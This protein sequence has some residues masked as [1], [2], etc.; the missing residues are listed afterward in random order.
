MCRRRFD[1][2][3]DSV[4]LVSELQCHYLSRTDEI[5][6]T[7]AVLIPALGANVI[8][9]S[10]LP[11]GWRWPIPV[12]ESVD[13]ASVLRSPTS[14]G[15][16]LLAPTP[17][18]V[19]Q[20]QSGRFCYHGQ[21]YRISPS[22]HGFLRDLPWRV[23][24]RA[25]DSITCDIE[26]TPSVNAGVIDAFPFRFHAEHHVQLGAGSLRS[27][28]RVCNKGEWSQPINVGWHPYLH[29]CSECIVRIPAS[30]RWKLDDHTEP[31]PTGELVSLKSDEDFSEGHRVKS[32][33]SW[34]DV[35]TGIMDENG[36]ARCWLEESVLVTTVGGTLERTA[37]RRFVEVAT[38][39]STAEH[40]AIRHVQLF[41]PRGRNAI[42]IEPLSCPPDAINL[43]AN[44]HKRSDVCELSPG[45][46]CYFDIVV[47]VS[48][49]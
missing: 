48:V 20:D 28:V 13:L 24:S 47:G 14:Y 4:A 9:L 16:P 42:S 38:E 3:Q 31:V 39:G 26:I 22:R 11:R 49:L 37:V 7:S 33:E 25:E 12:L 21:Q 41:T 10:Y 43:L 36:T 45:Q 34:D 5:G 17:G 35:F 6:T 30:M 44:G 40:R 27:R 1:E 15:M 23:L 2:D 18:R 19:G 8:A 32:D 29:R 46:E